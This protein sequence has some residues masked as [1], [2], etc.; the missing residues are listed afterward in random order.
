MNSLLQ[1]KEYFFPVV[2]VVANATFN[3]KND[4]VETTYNIEPSL[5]KSDENNLYQI[6]IDISSSAD[7]EQ[8]KLP[9]VVHIVA[10]GIFEI[11][12]EWDEPE[13]LLYINGSSILYSA[14]R[15]FLITITSRGPWDALY[16]PSVSFLKKYQSEAKEMSEKKS[17]PL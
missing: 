5:V 9:Y 3:D 11:N 15:E 10:V 16:L 2:Q 14:A 4:A 13:K 1:L 17:A 12:P 8:D 6:A 7:D